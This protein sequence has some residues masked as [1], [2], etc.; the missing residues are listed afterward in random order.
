MESVPI[1][2]EAL[3]VAGY[4]P[5]RHHEVVCD[6]TGYQKVFRGAAGEKL[7]FVNVYLWY[8]AKHF[9]GRG[10]SE[11]SVSCEAKLYLPEGNPLVSSAGF[12]LSMGLD[13]RATIYA[14]EAFYAK[15]FAALD[16][17]PDLHNND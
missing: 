5:F 16:C 3:I 2:K 10:G 6:N 7:Y 15:A 13:D 14:M 12:E 17:V 1:L 11:V 4:K 8:F 9:P